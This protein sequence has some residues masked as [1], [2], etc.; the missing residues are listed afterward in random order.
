MQKMQI[1]EFFYDFGLLVYTASRPPMSM[2]AFT[3]TEF[4]ILSGNEGLYADQ[5]NEVNI[6]VI[7]D[8]VLQFFKSALL[9]GVRRGIW[10][11]LLHAW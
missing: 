8:I 11:T 4:R 2:A 7:L 1:G 9:C 5:Q 6:R 10:Q 3:V